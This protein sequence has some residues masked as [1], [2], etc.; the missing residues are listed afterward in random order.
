MKRHHTESTTDTR[1]FAVQV[2]TDPTFAIFLSLILIVAFVY[3]CYMVWNFY[4]N[5]IA[6]GKLLM[7]YTQLS[8]KNLL[9]QFE[10]IFTPL[11]FLVP[12]TFALGVGYLFVS[13][14]KVFFKKTP[15][16]LVFSQDG[17]EFGG[18]FCSWKSMVWFGGCRAIFNKGVV[19]CWAIEKHHIDG[20]IL[21]SPSIKPIPLS[22]FNKICE[23]ARKRFS[24]EMAHLK[25]PSFETLWF[26]NDFPYNRSNETLVPWK[27][28][29]LGDCDIL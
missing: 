26:D 16:Y 27:T 2:Y 12:F 13:T 21:Y 3:S 7:W 10:I 15:H 19:P 24:S 28:R 17:V 23:E 14:V 29:Q 22:Q 6:N 25:S 8:Q 5:A 11:S 20:V 18:F 4:L 9:E 1:S